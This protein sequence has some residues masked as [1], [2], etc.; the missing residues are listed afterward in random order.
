MR[1]LSILIIVSATSIILAGCHPK[2]KQPTDCFDGKITQIQM[3]D[4]T[5]NIYGKQIVSCCEDPVTG[6][7]R[8][9]ICATGPDD[10]GTHIVCARMTKE[11]LS[12]SKA[13][14][15]DLVTPRPRYN[16]PGLNPGDHWCLCISR[17]VEAMKAGVAPPIK[18]DATHA[19]ALEY[20]R[21]PVLELYDINKLN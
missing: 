3:E 5:Y 7:Y 13:Q 4:V 16:F 8:N 15:N 9:G 10:Y 14:G 20:V 11:F 21:L 19:K 2:Q 1:Y 12:Y 18:L 6:F 17:W